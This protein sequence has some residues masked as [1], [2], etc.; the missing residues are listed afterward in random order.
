MQGDLV[1][2]ASARK[3]Q[4]SKRLGAKVGVIQWA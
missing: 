3:N 4:V 2:G 1:L